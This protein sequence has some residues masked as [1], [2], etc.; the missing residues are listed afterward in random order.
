MFLPTE[1]PAVL[2]WYE[3]LVHRCLANLMG[4]Q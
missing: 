4:S 2:I 3:E 1:E